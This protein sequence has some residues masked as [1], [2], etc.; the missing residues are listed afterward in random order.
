MLVLVLD[1]IG[2]DWIGL[3]WIELDWIGIELTSLRIQ[4]ISSIAKAE[5]LAWP[6]LLQYLIQ[7][8]DTNDP[9][10]MDGAFNALGKICEDM[11]QDLDAEEL[12]RPV[13]TL[14][15][16]FITF[17]THPSE[18]IRKYACVFWLGLKWIGL[19]WIGLD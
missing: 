14:I 17:C 7:M 11:T 5:R 18:S 16:K 8:L 13:N 4:L 10:K 19:V 2:L 15:P 3:N 9:N 12:G 6:G 1:W